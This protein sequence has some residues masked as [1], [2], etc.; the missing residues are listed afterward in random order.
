MRFVLQAALVVLLGA[1]TAR[2]DITTAAPDRKKNE[3]PDLRPPPPRAAPIEAKVA[4][5][6]SVE[7]PLHAAAAG[8]AAIKLIVRAQPQAGKLFEVRMNGRNSGTVVY[9]HNG[10][11]TLTR[12]QFSYAVQTGDGVSVAA[13]VNVLI[14]NEPP[15]LGVPAEMEFGS[16]RVG[17]TL[18]KELTIENRGDV[19]ARGALSL[20]APWSVDDAK[21]DLAPGEKKRVAV[22]FAPQ[23]E[24]EFRG[25]LRFGGDVAEKT[26]LQGTAVAPLAVTPRVK[27]TAR[28]LARTGSFGIENRT[29][30]PQTVLLR[31]AARLHTVE[32]VALEADGKATVTVD[33]RTNSA[34]SFDDEV[35]VELGNFATRVAVEVPA[36]T[37]LFRPE[38][39]SL[40][41]GTVLF[42]HDASLPVRVENIG[43]AAAWL[44]A[45]TAAPFRVTEPDFTLAPGEAAELRVALEASHAG[46]FSA[47]VTIKSAGGNLTI[48]VAAAVLAA[49]ATPPPPSSAEAPE[50]AAS[51]VAQPA[52][53]LGFPRRE[54]TVMIGDLRVTNVN[55][56]AADIAWNAPE[57]VAC[58]IEERILSFDENHHLKIDW[59]PATDAVLG[60]KGGRRTAHF[61]N[62]TS[63]RKYAVRIGLL[64]A[65]GEVAEE[66]PALEISTTVKMKTS[67]ALLNVL[68]IVLASALGLMLRRWWRW[69]R[70]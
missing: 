50:P 60:T 12:D 37:A 35:L 21:Y 4:R 59:I 33:T 56:K 5:G 6:G 62:L 8:S 28:G 11:T 17:D 63:G 7:I 65:N 57:N 34:Q 9:Q 15:K 47:S 36:A 61:S 55:T 20:D 32:R 48:P 44:S 64:G 40:N 25:V 26:A 1:M 43:G 41:F 13:K 51:Q 66:S 46:T 42:Q 3:K 49:G 24:D 39:A 38:P 70:R 27:L 54:R 67:V 31:S 16:L 18:T 22:L 45:E 23:S 10:E 58:R 69:H 19:P 29:H 14:V 2:G 53:T 30:E 52:P 68:W